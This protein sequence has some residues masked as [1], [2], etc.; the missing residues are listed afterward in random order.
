MTTTDTSP[1]QLPP[2][3]WV[4]AAERLVSAPDRRR[5]AERLVAN[6]RAHGINLKLLWGTT[7]TT[8]ENGNAPYVR[9]VVMGVPS[10]GR[11][12]MLFLSE[13]RHE[14]RFGPSLVQVKELSDC[15]RAAVKALPAASTTPIRLCQA[16]IEPNHTW[17][18]HAC[19]EAGMTWV[20]QLQF[21]RLPWP[22]TKTK[23]SPDGPWPDGV[24][25]RPV[26]DPDNFE[27]DG[28]GAA[29]ERA[30][31]GSY[32]DTRDCPELCGLRSTRDVIASHKATGAFDPAQWWLLERDGRAEGC[33][34]LNHC[35]ATHSVELVYLGLSPRARG[36][37]LGK[38][39]L[40][41]A[42][43]RA[44]SAGVREITCAVDTRNE[45]ALRLYRAMGFR[46][47]TSRVGFVHASDTVLREIKPTAAAQAL[48][49]SANTGTSRGQEKVE[50][51]KRL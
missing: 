37:G 45:P 13:P 30:L 21:L 22:S 23:E 27:P 32:E 6:A 40:L 10:P 50:H 3:L 47:F 35:P 46:A 17:A 28:C 16:L 19:R 25:V 48:E 4:P 18:D 8:G 31:N 5:A 2:A 9:Q 51:A 20:G 38:R 1:I 29:L 33:C 42:L 49:E 34:L 26:F 43:Q 12:G 24:A 14:R 39:L 7:G 44:P 41:H 15:I 11:T 36:L